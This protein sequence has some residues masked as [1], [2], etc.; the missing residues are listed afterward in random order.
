MIEVVEDREQG[1]IELTVDE[2]SIERDQFNRVLKKFQS[3]ID[4]WGSVRMIEV[5]EQFPKFGSGV[6]WDDL[7]F[8]YEHLDDITHCAVVS[9]N[10]WVGPYSRL[11]GALLHCKIRVFHSDDLEK[12]REWIRSSDEA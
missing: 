7:K 9:D 3:C 1:V 2:E 4:E 8:S 11:I 10:G 6:L 5:V 12:A